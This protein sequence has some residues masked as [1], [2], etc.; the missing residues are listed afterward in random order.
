MTSIRSRSAGGAGSR[1]MKS[2]TTGSGSSI[3]GGSPSVRGSVILPCRP[4]AAVVAG[5][6][7][8]EVDL[9]VDRA[10]GGVLDR[11]RRACC[12]QNRGGGPRQ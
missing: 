8:V 9:V 10:L 3:A 5:G 12:F 1:I 4:V 7:E 11:P 6:G 2:S